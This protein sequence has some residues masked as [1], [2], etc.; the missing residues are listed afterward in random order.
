MVG[1][2]WNALREAFCG[3]QS[4]RL[5]LLTYETLT[6]A[7]QLALEAVYDFIGEKMFAHDFDNI[8]FD[9]AEFDRRLG[10]PGLHTVD[11]RVQAHQRRSV[12]P[13]DLV[14]K[15]ENDSFWR[16]PTR[17]PNNVKVI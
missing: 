7:P 13:L 5:L 10:T 16:D 14:R 12:L 1:Y 6:A 17:N 2:A 4:D 3:E 11:R 8:E 9:V 15:Y